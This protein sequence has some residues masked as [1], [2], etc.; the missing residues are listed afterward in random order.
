MALG[1]LAY[2]SFAVIGDT[3]YTVAHN[4]KN[5]NCPAAA[6]RITGV[7]QISGDTGALGI[8]TVTGKTQIAKCT[9]VSANTD[10]QICLNLAWAVK[11]GFM[12]DSLYLED[13]DAVRELLINEKKNIIPFEACVQ[14]VL[15]GSLEGMFGA[16]RK[17][18]TAPVIIS[19]LNT[20]LVNRQ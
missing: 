4:L 8:V 1:V 10:P 18:L 7:T 15:S 16:T 9:L 11:P 12:I 19:V 17:N 6:A 13:P 2:Q 5:L 20:V 14:K 3:P